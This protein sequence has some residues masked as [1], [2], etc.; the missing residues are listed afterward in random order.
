M[1]NVSVTTV[2]V[3]KWSAEPTSIATKKNDAIKMSVRPLLAHLMLTVQE[4]MENKLVKKISV[5]MLIVMKIN[6][7]EINKFVLDQEILKKVSIFLSK[8]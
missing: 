1:V 2:L 5:L 7:V 8:I 6:I 4:K 3:R